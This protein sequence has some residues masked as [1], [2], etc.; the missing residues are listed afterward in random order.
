MAA[1]L[2]YRRSSPILSD[3]QYDKLALGLASRWDQLDEHLR[4][5]L[6]SPLAIV[7]T[8]HHIKITRAAEAGALLW[9]RNIKGE[10]PHGYPITSWL[11]SDARQLWWAAAEG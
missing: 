8:G 4:W 10:E 9:F 2:Y 7:T 11:W 3:T 1:Y 6:G 5:Q